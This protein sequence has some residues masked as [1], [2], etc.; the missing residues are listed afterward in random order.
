MTLARRGWRW[1]V[2][3]QPPPSVLAWRSSTPRTVCVHVVINAYCPHARLPRTLYAGSGRSW[4][5]T[6]QGRKAHDRGARSKTGSF[7]GEPGQI[8]TWKDR[9]GEL[10]SAGPS[11]QVQGR[12]GSHPPQ[13]T[14]GQA[15]SGTYAPE[16]KQ[17]PRALWPP[18]LDRVPV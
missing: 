11:S 16:S 8:Q 12:P 1:R 7:G 15:L 9:E 3:A 18:G 2:H 14:G 10:G 6:P 13:G 4:L 5:G 17:S